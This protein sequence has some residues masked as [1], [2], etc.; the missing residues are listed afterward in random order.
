MAG[1]GIGMN[2]ERPE[3]GNLKGERKEIACSCY[4]S[5]SGK[6][7]PIMIRVEDE[8]GEIRTI[9]QIQ[10]H[11]QE[12]KTY[13]GIPAEEYDCTIVILGQKVSV[14]LVHYLTES[15]WVMNFK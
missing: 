6:T 14:K 5:C 8:D 13:A 2:N 15:K 1:F 4:F 3:A 7:F 10:V 11:S 12:R 9:R